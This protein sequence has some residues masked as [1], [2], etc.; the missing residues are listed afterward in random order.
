MC[1]LGLEAL[2]A[3]QGPLSP[4][5]RKELITE[6]L[7]CSKYT[8]TCDG[9]SSFSVSFTDIRSSRGMVRFRSPGILFRFAEKHF[10]FCISSFMHAT[11]PLCCSWQSIRALPL[12]QVD[13]LFLLCFSFFLFQSWYLYPA[14]N[15]P[16]LRKSHWFSVHSIE[17]LCQVMFSVLFPSASALTCSCPSL[18]QWGA[19]LL[20][21]FSGSLCQT[22][23]FS[24][25][26]LTP[27]QTCFFHR[28]DLASASLTVTKSL[29][30]F[31][32]QI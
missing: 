2:E 18:S 29:L 28:V 17:F 7:T 15:T 32:I 22:T 9:W 8:D 20:C 24:L 16:I 13:P 4:G 21:P 25:S 30:L 19:V 27:C 1:F 26:I 3:I 14:C 10:I 6:K 12:S 23:H 11:P 31:D 5:W